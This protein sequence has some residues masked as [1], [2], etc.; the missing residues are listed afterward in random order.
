MKVGRTCP[1]HRTFVWN[2]TRDADRLSPCS[3]FR[4]PKRRHAN[5]QRRAP[6]AEH[7]KVQTF[8]C[9]PQFKDAPTWL[10]A[11]L[12]WLCRRLTP[13]LFVIPSTSVG[14]SDQFGTRSVA[15]G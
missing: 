14:S 7:G 6:K 10:D 13:G 1:E 4:L 12:A 9:K 2:V 3:I 5:A 15:S 11:T 8:L